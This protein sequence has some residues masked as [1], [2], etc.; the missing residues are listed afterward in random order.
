MKKQ[1][2]EVDGGY[3]DGIMGRREDEV[4]REIGAG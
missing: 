2:R 1:R 3:I 4:K